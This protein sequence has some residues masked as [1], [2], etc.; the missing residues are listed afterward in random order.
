MGD[1]WMPL[2][3][4]NNRCCGCSGGQEQEGSGGERMEG[5]ILGEATGVGKQFG[6]KVG[7]KHN[8]NFQDSIRVTLSETSNNGGQET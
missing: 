4:G 3:T 5:E 7:T 6:G 8:E 1:P 2:G